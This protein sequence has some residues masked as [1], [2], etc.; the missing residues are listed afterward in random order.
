MSSPSRT[1]T[2]GSLSSAFSTLRLGVSRA[3]TNTVAPWPSPELSLGPPCSPLGRNKCW[4]VIGPALAAS[5]NVLKA[6]KELLDAQAEY[7][8]EKE[9]KTCLI[10]FGVWM[11][12]KDGSRACPTLLVSCRRK[13]PR[14]K[15]VELIRESSILKVVSGFRLAQS[16]HTPLCTSI[17]IPLG[18]PTYLDTHEA[19]DPAMNKEL[20]FSLTGGTCGIPMYTAVEKQSSDGS[21]TYSRLGTIGGFVSVV[22]TIYAL[23]TVHNFIEDPDLQAVPEEETDS[24][25]EFDDELDS[26]DSSPKGEAKQL[27]RN[28]FANDFR[29][30]AKR[31]ALL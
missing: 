29:I 9:P 23:S 6:V 28:C 25:F 3:V 27:H 24:D 13:P 17:Q 22:E 18:P 2:E 26:E 12:G 14:L 31:T 11:M 15:A 8:H 20:Y 4:E 10:S 21:T 7:L 16:S 1:M 5:V 30:L 19:A